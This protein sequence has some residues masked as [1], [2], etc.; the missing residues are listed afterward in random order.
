M[1]IGIAL[2]N[3]LNE[4][5]NKEIFFIKKKLEQEGGKVFFRTAFGLAN[6]QFENIRDMI[7]NDKIDVLVL[8]PVDGIYAKVIVEYAKEHGVKVIAYSRPIEHND[9]DFHVKFDVPSIGKQQAEYVLNKKP[10]GNYLIIHGHTRDLNTQLLLE[11]QM[12]I[13]QPKIDAGEINLL[14]TTYLSAWTK[15]K[16]IECV[17]ETCSKLTGKVDVVIA[18]NDMIA[19]ALSEYF[20]EHNIS[21]VLTTGLDAEVKACLRI[22]DNKQTMTVMLVSKVIAECVADTALYLASNDS[23]YIANYTVVNEKIT[24]TVTTKCIQLA[25]EVIDSDNVMEKVEEYK[26]FPISWFT[27]SNR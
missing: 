10:T 8:V 27:N 5:W 26:I 14:D 15:L 22:A 23:K 21:N 4:R 12:Q 17:K 9:I 11:G 13:L 18:A 20:E 2:D 24:D 25:C 3:T 6:S 1:N 16:A 19:E 7:A